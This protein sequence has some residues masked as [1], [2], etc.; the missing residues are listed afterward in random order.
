[1]L[2]LVSLLLDD[3]AY[4]SACI[5]ILFQSD[6]LHSQCSK[7]PRGDMQHLEKCGAFLFAHTNLEN[8]TLL[9]S[10]SNIRQ[11][12]MLEPSKEEGGVWHYAGFKN[13]GSQSLRPRFV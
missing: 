1:M 3:R 9:R 4:C 12:N 11:I 13:L 5:E 7:I 10:F 8:A 2:L 6:R